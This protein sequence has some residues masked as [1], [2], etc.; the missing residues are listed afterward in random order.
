MGN[1]LKKMCLE[2]KWTFHVIC[3]YCYK[4]IAVKKQLCLNVD[5]TLW[6]SVFFVLTIDNVYKDHV[7]GG[8]VSCFYGF[9]LL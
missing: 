1:S 2:I 4:I 3:T 6:Y 8:I 7:K 5:A 9:Q